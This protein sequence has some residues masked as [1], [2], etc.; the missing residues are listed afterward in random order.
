MS[1]K[2]IKTLL[3]EGVKN[4][5]KKDALADMAKGIELVCNGEYGVTF[6]NPEKNEIYICLGD[7]NPFDTSALEEYVLDAVSSYSDRDKI[8]I[9]IDHESYPNEGEGWLVYKNDNFEP[10]EGHFR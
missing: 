7:S 5:I 3:N 1:K 8:S 6:Y 4:I 2:L 9:D 10:W